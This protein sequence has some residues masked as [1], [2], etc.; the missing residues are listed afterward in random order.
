[1]VKLK[2]N[3]KSLSPSLGI[4][5]PVCESTCES[6]TNSILECHLDYLTRC[7][8][9]YASKVVGITR[10]PGEFDEYRDQLIYDMVKAAAAFKPHHS[11]KTF[12]NSVMR[13][14]AYR[15]VRKHIKA[16]TI[17]AHSGQYNT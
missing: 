9:V 7:A 2:G 3:K 14:A 11:F 4:L 10:L 5:P 16:A 13:R 12:C 15:I 8:E 17:F 6:V 1:M